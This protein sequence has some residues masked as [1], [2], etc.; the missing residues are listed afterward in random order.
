[1]WVDPEVQTEP[2]LSI[3]NAPKALCAF[4]EALVAGA[5][6][7]QDLGLTAQACPRVVM[8]PLRALCCRLLCLI[9]LH[10]LAS[11]SSCACFVWLQLSEGTLVV[12]VVHKP[13]IRMTN[14]SKESRPSS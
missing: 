12:A 7:D 9:S 11:A 14:Q 6:L 5:V 1:M 3:L 8:R 4:F 10:Q 2:L 13:E